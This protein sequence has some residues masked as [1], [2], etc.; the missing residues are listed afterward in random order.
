MPGKE[1]SYVIK[2]KVQKDTSGLSDIQKGFSEFRTVLADVM[3]PFRI[4]IDGMRISHILS[5]ANT[6]D[7]GD[8]SAMDINQ[9]GVLAALTAEQEGY[10]SSLAETAVLED[11]VSGGTFSLAQMAGLGAAA[12]VGGAAVGAIAGGYGG[13]GGG[14]V[15]VHMNNVSLNPQGMSLNDFT[16]KAGTSIR[17][18]LRGHT[19]DMPI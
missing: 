9:I 7:M 14:D 18:N 8:L 3:L 4:F 16:K 15:H 13:G 1:K 6:A 12:V 19:K 17:N 5:L 11:V 2:I 10:N